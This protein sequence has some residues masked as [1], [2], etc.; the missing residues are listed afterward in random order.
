MPTTMVSQN[1]GDAVTQ[2]LT[3]S[4]GKG[5]PVLQE[6]LQKFLRWSGRDRLVSQLNP[7]QIESYCEA[8][9]GAPAE[10]LAA[11]KSFLDYAFKSG[12]TET[13]LGTHVKMRKGLS[14]A[15]KAMPSAS[16]APVFKLT[17][18]GLAKAQGEVLELKEQRIQVADDIRRAM[19]DK[20]FRENAPLDAAR[21]KQGHLEARIRELEH[22][23]RYA[24]VVESDSS[25][26]TGR[27]RQGSR[28]VVRDM[29]HNE[30]VVYTLVDRSEVNLRLGKLSIQSPA[31][32]AFLGRAP[33]DLVKVVAPNGQHQYRIERVE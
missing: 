11:L 21:D 19:A 7:Y 22:T 15:K 5:G 12:L 28:V 6:G 8:S 13:S 14:K 20:D 29:T 26:A 1:L 4:N 18:E 25:T 9:A 10:K 27:A 32:K 24:Q 2:F 33:G 30:E 31:G 3:A 17:K 23:L 16:S